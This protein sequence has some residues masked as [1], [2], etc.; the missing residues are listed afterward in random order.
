M[1]FRI[2]Q[3]VLKLDVP[4]DNA[5]RMDVFKPFPQLFIPRHRLRFGRLS[6]LSRVLQRLR[7]TIGIQNQVHHE[8][9]RAVALVNG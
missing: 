4:M 6:R 5:L 3:H 1:T 7:H 2:Q 8:I 9:R